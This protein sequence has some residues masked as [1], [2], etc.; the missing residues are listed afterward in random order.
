M[1]DWTIQLSAD[2]PRLTAGL[3]DILR[4][5]PTLDIDY[6]PCFVAPAICEQLLEAFRSSSQMHTVSAADSR[7]KFAL[8][9]FAV[10]SGWT[11]GRPWQSLAS[12]LC[13]ETPTDASTPHTTASEVLLQLRSAVARV[14]EQPRE[15]PTYALVNIYRDGSDSIG[16]HADDAN[17][18]LPD[19]SIASISL[20]ASRR[21]AFR[22]YVPGVRGRTEAW[23]QVS[24]LLE[25]DSLLLMG[26]QTNEWWCHSLA[27]DPSVS[28]SRVNITF[29]WLLPAECSDTAAAECSAAVTEARLNRINNSAGDNYE[30]L[31]RKHHALIPGSH[32]VFD[33]QPLHQVE[34]AFETFMLSQLQEQT[35]DAAGWRQMR[36]QIAHCSS[37]EMSFN[38]VDVVPHG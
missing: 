5:F 36:D 27:P 38:L 28:T 14:V 37:P 7:Q 10:T 11:P 31:A 26:P 21:F 22:P 9:D 1:A 33:H 2:S 17:G 32:L 34:A 30:R 4:L 19:S 6:Q 29:R 18:V 8:S 13:H 3:P 25:S 23:P 35:Q 24:V 20:G 12:Q 15:E 16:W